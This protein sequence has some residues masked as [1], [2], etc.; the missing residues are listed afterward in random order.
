MR[1]SIKTA[2]REK[3]GLERTPVGGQTGR[4]VWRCGL[5]W[6]VWL[7]A[8]GLSG[9]G[10]GAG[11][12]TVPN[13]SFETPATT[14]VSTLID[15]WQ[16]TPKPEWYSE[17]GGFMWDQLTGLFLNP[18]PTSP[19]HID[20][21]D[22]NQALWLFAVPEVGLF[23]ELGG[24]QVPSPPE[25]VYEVGSSYRLT[26]A[27]MGGGGSML[28]GVTLELAFYYRDDASNQVTVAATTI[29]NTPAVFSNLK[30]FIDFEVKVPTVEAGDAWAGR[31][32]GLRLLSTVDTARQG[33][34]WDLDQVRLR[35]IAPPAFVDVEVIDGEVRLSLA[36]EP[37]DKFEL[38]TS[39]DPAV[40]VAYW[41]HLTT[42]TNLSGRVTYAEPATSAGHRFYRARSTE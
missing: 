3:P 17:G 40:P 23:Q 9:L 24:G 7:W 1:A 22:G 38:L 28:E 8:G 36:G 19:N 29:T 33:G 6:V 42:L 12:L 2:A 14:F 26:V 11:E 31:P 30:H 37:G 10:V 4:G 5:A 32:I 34:Y 35:S 20:N 18:E 25:T 21:C 16:K 15:D 13:A 39:A 27:V 41:E